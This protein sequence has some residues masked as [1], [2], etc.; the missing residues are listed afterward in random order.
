MTA[1]YVEL[2]GNEAQGMLGIVGNSVTADVDDDCESLS[3]L[4]S[5]TQPIEEDTAWPGTDDGTW[6]LMGGSSD[7]LQ[8][9]VHELS[10]HQQQA[11][12]HAELQVQR[13]EHILQL[14]QMHSM[15]IRA[16]A[17]A[18]MLWCE[19]GVDPEMM[20]YEDAECSGVQCSLQ[21]LQPGVVQRTGCTEIELIEE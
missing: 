8:P 11:L 18:R 2:E 4:A 17:D 7:Y 10:L 16:T 12:L 1:V 6:M 9:F 13:H 14:Q 19:A 21:P 20:A 5:V 3:E 15:G